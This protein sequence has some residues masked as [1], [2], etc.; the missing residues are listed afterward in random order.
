VLQPS[1]PK[2]LSSKV[3]YSKEEEKGKK[4]SLMILWILVA[5]VVISP[6]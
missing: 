1:N 3:Q 4:Y 5:S 2:T 6:F